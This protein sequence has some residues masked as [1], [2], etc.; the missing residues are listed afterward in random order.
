MASDR[1]RTE[2]M[3][4]SSVA[5]SAVTSAARA[6]IA[7]N[8]EWA[9]SSAGAEGANSSI[10][11][12]RFG[13][14]DMRCRLV[15]HSDFISRRTLKER[16]FPLTLRCSR[17]LRKA[18]DPPPPTV[19]AFCG[20]NATRSSRSIASPPS[21]EIRFW[22][23]RSFCNV[24]FRCRERQMATA[25]SSPMFAFEA[26]SE[27]RLVLRTSAAASATAPGSPRGLRCR[28]I[29]WMRQL[30]PRNAAPSA[31]APLSFMLQPAIAKDV[32]REQATPRQSAATPISPM[33]GLSETSR[34]RRTQSAAPSARPSSM[35]PLRP[36]PMA[37]KQRDSS[38]AAGGSEPEGAR[39][40]VGFTGCTRAATAAAP[41]PAGAE[42]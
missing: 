16:E 22:S 17:Q 11:R 5:I 15:S 27:R 20:A 38:R 29:D 25:P 30:S 4:A 40:G 31:A 24:L 21:A 35:A 19:V 13:G 36:K 3:L 42:D 28:R 33:P 41:R 39:A 1:A 6:S 14:T 2:R 7:A 37:F 18:P 26:S 10:S 32:T 9:E 34:E 23:N 8:S 12:S